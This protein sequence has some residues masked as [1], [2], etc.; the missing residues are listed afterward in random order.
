VR[1]NAPASADLRGLAEA[2]CAGVEAFPARP[3]LFA[4]ALRAVKRTLDPQGM[5]NPGV[6]V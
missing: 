1:G 4:D 2:G 3:D 6:L 5:L